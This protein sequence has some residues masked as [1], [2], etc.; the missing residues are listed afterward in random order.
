MKIELKDVNWEDTKSKIS[1]Y[2]T[3]HEATFLPQWSVYHKP[4]DQE[5][6]NILKLADKMDEIRDYFEQPVNIS[7]W[8]RPTA[9]NAPGSKFD[10]K[11]YNSLIGGKAMSA[12]IEGKAADFTISRIGSVEAKYLLQPMLDQFQVRMENNGDGNWVHI[13]V[14]EVPPGGK[15]FFKP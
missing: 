15:R 14:R 4:S 6:E 11:N 10:G 8:I 9:V 2:F 3:V 13:D 5:K 1:Q 12:H 7:C